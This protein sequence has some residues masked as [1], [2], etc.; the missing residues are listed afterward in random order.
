MPSAPRSGARASRLPTPPELYMSGRRSPTCLQ[1]LIMRPGKAWDLPPA[2]LASFLTRN[3]GSRAG[4]AVP[5]YIPSA[6]RSGACVI[7][8]LMPR[9]VMLE[10]SG[11]T[12]HFPDP[13]FL[14]ARMAWVALPMVSVPC[15]F[16]FWRD[17]QTFLW[18][19]SLLPPFLT[20]A[21]PRHPPHP[22]ASTYSHPT[23]RNPTPPNPIRDTTSHL[24]LP[25]PSPP[26]HYTHPTPSTPP[27][28]PGN[29]GLL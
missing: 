1:P 3:V 17:Q 2:V 22:T 5:K 16:V 9:S 23:P 14:R 25:R 20:Q 26:T 7:W 27:A 12:Y 13:R 28:K 24:T 11:D 29:H 21:N 19:H 10:G 15:S 18:P 4:E 6:S 8:L